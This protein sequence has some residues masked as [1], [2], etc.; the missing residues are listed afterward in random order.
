L[1]RLCQGARSAGDTKVFE[2]AA[3]T[4]ETG[5]WALHGALARLPR[6]DR[7]V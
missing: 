4:W 3:D 6:R 1:A 5:H 2:I 7:L